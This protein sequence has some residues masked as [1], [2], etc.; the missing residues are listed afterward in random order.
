MLGFTFCAGSQRAERAQLGHIGD[1]TAL[2][3]CAF[4]SEY[5]D[6]EILH[7]EALLLYF[8]E[9]FLECK[10]MFYRYLSKS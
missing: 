6:L 3:R 10:M 1:P 9:V 7:K 4:W 2:T 5:I 8:K